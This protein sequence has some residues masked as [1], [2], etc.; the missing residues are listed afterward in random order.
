MSRQSNYVLGYLNDSDLRLLRIFS[1]I[2]EC[3]GVTPAESQLNMANSTLSSHLAAL[4][5]NLQMKLC[6]RGRA[7]FELTPEGRMVYEAAERMFR[8]LED[9]GRSV[10]RAKVAS[11]AQ[12]RIL[13]PDTLICVVFDEL[14]PAFRR[15]VAEVP[16]IFIDI[17]V[18]SPA[19]IDQAVID[20]KIDMGINSSLRRTHNLRFY[21]VRQETMALFCGAGHPLFTVPDSALSVE[22]LLKHK[23]VRAHGSY[24]PKKI[25]HMLQGVSSSSCI[26]VDARALLVATGHYLGLMP[27]EVVRPYVQRGLLREL[28]PEVFRYPNDL[29]IVTRA[30]VE[31]PA[32]TKF[33]D[34]LEEELTAEHAQASQSAGRRAKKPSRPRRRV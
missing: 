24:Y 22:K 29:S 6:R 10:Q 28:M 15:V 16:D 32:L 19:D 18:A 9:F 21:D 13:V 12:L 4:E 25:L 33:L 26:P 11:P 8:S 23:F 2:V 3:G 20:G 5:D 7:G 31:N 27:E 14:L 17:D 1:T 30:E 34:I